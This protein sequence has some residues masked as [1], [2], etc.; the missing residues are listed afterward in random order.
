MVLLTIVERIDRSNSPIESDSIRN[1]A[2]D[3]S[4]AR[5]MVGSYRFAYL[6]F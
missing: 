1:G 4:S 6:E 2:D 5:V 3:T